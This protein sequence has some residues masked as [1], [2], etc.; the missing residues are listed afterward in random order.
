MNNRTHDNSIQGNN[1]D[2]CYIVTISDKFT[3]DSLKQL[4]DDTIQ[5]AHNE[6][7]KGIIFSF[8][9]VNIVDSFSLHLLS[10]V[11]RTIS[12]FGVDVVWIGLKPGI[13]AT[14]LDLQINIE[15]IEFAFDVNEGIKIIQNRLQ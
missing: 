8:V 12:L 3:D 15:S 9:N 14:V 2:D 13:I 6:K 7:I 11:T 10:D 1:V 5:I 4:C